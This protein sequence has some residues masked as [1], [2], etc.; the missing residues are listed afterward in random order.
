MLRCLIKMDDDGEANISAAVSRNKE[1]DDY[2]HNDF[3]NFKIKPMLPCH[4]KMAMSE[5][6]VEREVQRL[7]VLCSLLA[8][9]A[10]YT[11]GRLTAMQ[12]A[13]KLK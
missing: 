12:D 6:D 7:S 5:N 13:L 2:A 11:E 3:I 4:I 1:S 8:I 9:A 10:K